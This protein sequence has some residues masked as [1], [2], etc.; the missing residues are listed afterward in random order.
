MFNMFYDFSPCVLIINPILYVH[1]IY[2]WISFV[3]L[4]LNGG[5]YFYFLV[6]A[7]LFFK[8]LHFGIALLFFISL[9]R[10]VF[11]LK[12]MLTIWYTFI[13]TCVGLYFFF[14]HF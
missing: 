5:V 14:P 4:F 10:D 13:F 7:E 9:V 6:F 8:L 1:V 11:L 12:D 3:H 2:Y